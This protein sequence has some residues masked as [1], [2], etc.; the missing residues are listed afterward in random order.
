MKQDISLKMLQKNKDALKLYKLCT[1]LEKKV[2][3]T[4]LRLLPSNLDGKL[5]LFK[6]ASCWNMNNEFMQGVNKSR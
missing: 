6:K 5:V 1:S 2:W 3:L 4:F